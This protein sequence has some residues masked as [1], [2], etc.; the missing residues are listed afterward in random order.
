MA[1]IEVNVIGG[2]DTHGRTHHA[3]ALDGA[4]RLLGDREFPATLAGYRALQVWLTGFGTLMAVGVEGTGTYGAGLARHLSGVGVRVIEV[5]RPDRRTRRA[6]GKSDPID[7]VAAAR[8]VQAGTATGVPKTRTGPVE[9]L[10]ALKV[11]RRGA[12]KAKVAA[13][14]QI[15]GLLAAAPEPLRAS[16]RGLTATELVAR[17][18]GFRIDPGRLHDPVMATKAALNA[19]ARRVL[20]LREEIA[21]ADARITP[22]VTELA[23]STMGLPGVGPQVATQLLITAGDNPER[24]RNEAALAH[25]CGAAPLP[26]SSGRTDRHRLNRGGDRHANNALHTVVLSRMKYHQPTRDYV[27]R[28]TKDG[29]SKKDIIRCLKR[30]IVREIHAALIKNFNIPIRP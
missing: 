4:G 18:A 16:L 5:D 11:A 9:A 17:A 19:V 12:V 25:L 23:P 14:N 22:A 26:A 27:Q 10:R 3:A 30:Y 1:S 6:Q 20:A 13:L 28:R 29:L 15:H 7:A 24:L 2:V 8:A 21:L